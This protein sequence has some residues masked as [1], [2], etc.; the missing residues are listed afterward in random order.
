MTQP[1]QFLAI[2]LLCSCGQRNQKVAASGAFTVT[3]PDSGMAI[4][5]KAA[6]KT[7]T[8]ANADILF[9]V[10]SSNDE[11]A[12]ILHVYR[13]GKKMLSHTL[14]KSDGDCSSINIEIGNYKWRNNEI[15][16]YSYW[17]A[18][19]RQNIALYPFGFRKQTYSIEETGKII[20]QK[21]ELF[22]EDNVEKGV[23]KEKFYAAHSN[24][25][26]KGLGF[27]YTSPQNDFEKEAKEDYIRNIEIMYR[28]TFVFGKRKE[29]LEKEVRQELSKEI[30]LHTGDWK[31][32]EAFGYGMVK[33]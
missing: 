19:D 23:G 24:W 15:V 27:I 12:K 13:N 22:I 26:H 11:G 4:P 25:K 33:K 14:F 2:I 17:A 29:A 9:K 1:L 30:T 20:K 10:D 6:T 5:Q 8:Y 16:F 28:G 18:T 21:A 3:A 31:A 32:G 7:T